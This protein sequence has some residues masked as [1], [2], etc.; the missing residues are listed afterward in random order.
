MSK[1]KTSVQAILNTDLEK[2][3]MQT[4]QLSDFI[5]GELKCCKCGNVITADNISLLIPEEVDN[6]IKFKF[7]CTKLECNTNI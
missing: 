5:D 7:V 1:N 4:D 2:L 3:L 6:V